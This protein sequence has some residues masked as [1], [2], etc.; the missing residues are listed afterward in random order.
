MPD[1]PISIA[2][3]YHER[4]K[5]DPQTIASKSKGLDW[6]QQPH[7]FKEYKI[8]QTFDLKPYL[9]RQIVPQKGDFW[10]RISRILGCSYG[11]TAKI[12]T[13]GSPLYL[14]SAPSAGGLYPA[15]VYLICRGT[16]FLPAGLYSYQGQSHSLLLFWESDVWTNLQSACFWNPVLENTDIA[17]VTSAI[18][19]RSAWRYEDRAYRRIFLDT[20]HLLGN[21]ELSASINDYRAH[22]IGGFNDSQM[23]ELLYLDSEKESVMTVIP[24]ADL[25]NIRQN[26]PPSTTA[27]PSAT[28]T[29]YPKIAEGELL[30]SL[31]RATIIATDEK[32]EA[33]ITPSNWEDKYNFPFCLK[34]SVT[35]R[36][37]NW[38]E[39]LVDLESTML[40]RRSTRAYS[41]ASLSLD[42]LRALLHF[43]YQPQDYADQNLDPNPDYFD[44][45]LLETFI[46]VSA[47]TGLEEG[48]YY[49][50][51]KAQELR[52][53]RF[54]NFQQ[55]LHYLC[56]GQDLGRD[57]AAVVFHT[58]DL[59]KAVAKY[60]DRV[61]RY[62]HA[63]AGHLGQRLNLAAIHLG[64]GVSGI[65]GF[66]DDQVNEVLGIPS[67]EAVI[68]ITT[69]G[70]PK[71]F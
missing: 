35:S 69:L 36:P 57:A 1:Q 56:L 29:L 22:L 18:F 40:K 23:N 13:M 25:L 66:F 54:K 8:G 43:T 5:Y 64:L 16:E 26:L 59:S 50:A 55:E 27:L 41:G 71:V 39:D 37:V 31:H 10:R 52:Q 62:L 32:I 30:N 65:G 14:R 7:P 17:L 49:Y 24:L 61:Y 51:P 47:V 42:E 34:V 68:Y 33:N 53:I 60:G 48:C 58:A 20:G 3:Y 21:I 4:T 63:D 44:L 11:L 28:T 46:A 19:Y 70:R 38:G 2:Q 15:E 45:D 12:A 9:S 67:D 6:S